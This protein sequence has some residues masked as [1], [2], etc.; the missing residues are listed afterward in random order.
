ME[1][2]EE[3]FDFIRTIHIKKRLEGRFLLKTLNHA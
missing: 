3:D 1:C 2:T